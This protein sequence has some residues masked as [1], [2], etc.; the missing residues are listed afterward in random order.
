LTLRSKEDIPAPGLRQARQT[1][2]AEAEAAEL[3]LL[4]EESLAREQTW[5]TKALQAQNQIEEV[6]LTEQQ[7]SLWRALNF[8]E[9]LE[10]TRA[11]VARLQADRE[12]ALAELK[13]ELERTRAE[14]ARLQADRERVL[15][16]NA[17][18]SD[19]RQAVEGSGAWR[20]IQFFRKLV[21]RKW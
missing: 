6:R 12:R 19:Y 10:R 11:E 13:E 20:L 8:E 21:G 3:R 17:W 2:R 5:L 16:E 18:L 1:G 9:E 7:L 15:A 14:V 4:L